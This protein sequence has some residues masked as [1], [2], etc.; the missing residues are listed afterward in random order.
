MSCADTTKVR[1]PCDGFGKQLENALATEFPLAIQ[2]L[3][4]QLADQSVEHHLLPLYANDGRVQSPV[5][6]LSVDSAEI[7]S[8]I[9]RVLALDDPQEMPPDEAADD[10]A[11]ASDDCSTVYEGSDDSDEEFDSDVDEEAQSVHSTSTVDSSQASGA[12]LNIQMAVAS[13][14]APGKRHRTPSRKLVES[15]KL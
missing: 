9:D 6:S 7:S 3:L 1:G 15:Q 5:D 12:L 14:N 8:L 11:N 13:P 10:L 4:R 2:D